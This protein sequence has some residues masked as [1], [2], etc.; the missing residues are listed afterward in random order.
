MIAHGEIEGERIRPIRVVIWIACLLCVL[1][2]GAMPQGFFTMS[3]HALFDGYA[4]IV[5][6]GP[7]PDDILVI[8]IDDESLH[9]LGQWPWPRDRLARLI[10]AAGGARVVGVDILLTERDRL[11]PTALLQRWPTLPT[12]T[13]QALSALPDTDAQLA[14]SMARVPVVL[15]AAAQMAVEDQPAAPV[16]VTPIFEAGSE[17]RRALPHYLSAAWPLPE[18]LAAARGVGLATVPPDADGVIR[19]VPLVFEVGPAL[20]PSFAAE[21]ARIASKAL[22][23][24]LRAGSAGARWIVIGDHRIE[25]D[26][27]SRAWPALGRRAPPQTVPAYRVLDGSADPSLFREKIVLIG[28]GAAGLG[29]VVVTPRGDV[30]P[31]LV[32]EAQLVDSLLNGTVLRRPPLAKTGEV[33]LA[34]LLAAVAFVLLGRIAD[35]VYAALFVGIAAVLVVGSF[36]VFRGSGILLD[37]TFPLS[38]LASTMLIAFVLRITDEGRARRL[39]E[40]E[41]AVALLKAEAAD[42]AKTEFLA[43]ASHELRTPLTAILGFSDVMAHELFGP[44]LP[45]Y[46]DYAR[47]IHKTATHLH[48]IITDILDL[49]VIGLGGKE[50]GEDLIDVAALLKDCAT[51]M[52]MDR[53]GDKVRIIS[54]VSA[55]LPLLKADGRMVKQMVLNLLSNAVKYSP[56]GGE[57]TIR[58]A[59][60]R[61]GGLEIA[62]RDQGPGIAADD[63]PRAMQQFGR[64]RSSRLAQEPGIGIGLPLTKSMIELHGGRLVLNSEIGVG[65]EAI[66][67]FPASRLDPSRETA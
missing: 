24:E 28:T 5:A 67:C 62:V 16:A 39:K 25:I 20:M 46:R 15:A 19:R 14:A 31:G 7:P 3:A 1:T 64:L 40:R 55:S 38:A 37:W 50:P 54:E 66:L 4:R 44:L 22:A 13:Q 2:I 9:R 42:R 48:A 27:D 18:F 59:R 35:R 32:A 33:A 45:K 43:N 52:P 53:G 63:I 23:I 26:G 21:M 47:D 11:S 29:D 12:D 58:A 57:I 51:M 17:S 65:T 61:E 41:L 34:L 36:L 60:I 30:E 56:R 6:P 8:D 49:A 10:D